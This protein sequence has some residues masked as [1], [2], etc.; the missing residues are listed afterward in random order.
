MPAGGTEENER[1]EMDLGA[2][3]LLS[4]NYGG[5][6]SGGAAAKDERGFFRKGE[7]IR[8]ETDAFQEGD[9][10]LLEHFEGSRLGGLEVQAGQCVAC[11]ETC[12]TCES[13]LFLG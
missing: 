7:L 8:C 9:Q 10:V 2:L 6:L 11:G 1:G 4:G 3:Q 5:G 13:L 12:A